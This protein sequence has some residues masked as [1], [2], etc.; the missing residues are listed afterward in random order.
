MS[1]KYTPAIVDAL[2]G[3]DFWRA[4]LAGLPELMGTDD[5]RWGN[6]NTALMGLRN[7]GDELSAAIKQENQS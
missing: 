5:P 4:E 3:V 2:D 7:C 1:D 6:V